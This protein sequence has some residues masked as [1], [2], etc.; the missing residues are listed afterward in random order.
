[1]D[2]LLR[3]L[4]RIGNKRAFFSSLKTR[5]DT[6]FIP[7]K[8]NGISFYDWYSCI[9]SGTHITWV[10]SKLLHTE[11]DSHDRGNF[12]PNSVIND[13]RDFGHTQDL[14]HAASEHPLLAP[15][16][17]PNSCDLFS[18]S[19]IQALSSSMPLKD[20]LWRKALLPLHGWASPLAFSIPL[21][22]G[23]RKEG[24]ANSTY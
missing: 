10:I 20:S 13:S 12:T 9:Q 6:Q 3:Q 19:I 4:L 5:A 23:P 1:M 15:F 18:N 17:P 2:P 14:L 22:Q 16:H 21:V 24:G 7:E 11:W 8:K